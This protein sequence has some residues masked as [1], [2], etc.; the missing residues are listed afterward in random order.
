[1]QGPVCF[2]RVNRQ[3]RRGDLREWRIAV[4]LA[5]RFEAYRAIVTGINSCLLFS[6]ILYFIVQLFQL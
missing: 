6:P 3:Y 5:K 4:D 1:M 2:G